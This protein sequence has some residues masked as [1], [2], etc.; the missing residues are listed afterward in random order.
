MHLG[1]GG[2]DRVHEGLDEGEDGGEDA[3][4]VEEDDVV[5]DLREVRL[6]LR[7][8]KEEVVTSTCLVVR[9]K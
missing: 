5:D 1:L 7:G 6:H 8:S 4:R 3:R 2:G 9:R